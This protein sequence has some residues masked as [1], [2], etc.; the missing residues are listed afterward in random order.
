[1]EINAQ[2]FDL[3]I[4]M[5]TG[6]VAAEIGPT[7][8]DRVCSNAAS[9]AITA[10]C[11]DREASTFPYDFAVNPTVAAMGR[12]VLRASVAQRLRAVR[13]AEREK[14]LRFADLI[15]LDGPGETV[16]ASIEQ[17]ARAHCGGGY[18]EVDGRQAFV[19]ESDSIDY[20]YSDPSCVVRLWWVTPDEDR[21]DRSVRVL[22]RGAGCYSTDREHDIFYTE[23][24]D[25]LAAAVRSSVH[26]DW[27]G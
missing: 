18:V 17:W 22:E 7:D 13:D 6:Y 3:I 20:D 23:M 12:P 1:M 5:A 2:H 11:K 8:T 19:D 16:G 27:F 4:D 25:V 9:R 10:L 21:V 26:R 24:T 15:F 14:Y